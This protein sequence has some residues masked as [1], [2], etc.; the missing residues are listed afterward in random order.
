M[1]LKIY[2]EETFEFAGNYHYFFSEIDYKILEHVQVCPV[3]F[4]SKLMNWCLPTST[5]IK[6]LFK[7]IQQKE[8][9]VATH[10]ILKWLT[11]VRM[12]FLFELNTRIYGY[13]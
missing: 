7:E 10:K 2:I 1:C 6:Q 8:N 3:R 9:K 5:Y 4:K 13:A 11:G 12:H